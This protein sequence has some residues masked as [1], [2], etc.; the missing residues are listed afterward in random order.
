MNKEL[1]KGILLVTIGAISYGVLTTLVGLAYN[2]GFT[3]MEVTTAQFMVGLLAMSLLVF[4]NGKTRQREATGV[5]DKYAIP[6]L[7]LGGT[8]LSLTSLFYYL[9]VQYIPVSIGVVLLMQSIWMG[10]V[11]ESLL[12]KKLPGTQ[13]TIAVV[14]VLTGTL[15][16][17]NALDNYHQLDARGIFWGLAAAVLYTVSIFVSTRI[18]LHLHPQTRSFWNLIGA[19]AIVLMI[20]AVERPASFNTAV[21]WK[22]GTWLA[23]SGTILPPL[24]FNTGLPKTGMGLGSILIAIEIPVSVCLAWLL[25]HE[26]VIPGQWA[27]VGLIIGAVVLMN[28]NTLKKELGTD[29][30]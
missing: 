14:L 2:E 4:F 28:I 19:A 25:L 9:S 13:K 5:K 6:K 10:V 30:R 29:I 27:G 7:I 11:G 24:L 20:I 21:I 1:L 17:T 12:E 26:E 18:A 22:W 15:L 3:A 8:S 23:L 16:A